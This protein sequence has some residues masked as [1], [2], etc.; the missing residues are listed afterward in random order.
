[1]SDTPK[2]DGLYHKTVSKC[3]GLRHAEMFAHARQLERREK[4]LREAL[5]AAEIALDGRGHL[6][7]TLT[8]V[9]AALKETA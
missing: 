6:G 5:Q 8:I 3:D 1:M 7:D 2:T 4:V 9:S